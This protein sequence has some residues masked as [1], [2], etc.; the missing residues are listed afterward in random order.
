MVARVQE[1]PIN[2]D[3]ETAELRRL[4]KLSGAIVT[5]CGLVRD[6]NHLGKIE[7]IS[8]EHYPGMTE[9]TLLRLAQQAVKRF[10]LE[11]VRIIHRVGR[12]DNAETIVWVGCAAVHRQ[13]AFAGAAYIMD[14]LKQDVP[15]WKKEHYG[16]SSV[17]V[18]AKSTDKDAASRWQK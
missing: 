11:Q 8:L 13:A 15:L 6:F 10:E 17:W 9:K 7:G 5:F 16:E 2:S 14:I 3:Y 12:I 4:L 1:T 18:E